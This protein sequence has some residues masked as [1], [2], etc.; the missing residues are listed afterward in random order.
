MTVLN[1]LN[2]N[3]HH[4]GGGG[5]GAGGGNHTQAV[6]HCTY[7]GCPKTYSRRE[8]LNRHI[9][10]HMGIE[11]E[12][13]YYCLDCGKTFTRKEHLLR[14]RRSHTGETPYHCPG[15]DC[16]KQFAR[17]EH[18]KRHMRVHTGEHPYPCSEC[19]RSFGR[20]ERLLKHLETHGIHEL[21]H[22]PRTKKPKEEQDPTDLAYANL[23]KTYPKKEPIKQE[24]D[25]N[26]PETHHGVFG[27]TSELLKMITQT[28]APLS[29]QQ[30]QAYA[31][32]QVAAQGALAA[33]VSPPK[34]V[35]TSGAEGQPPATSH[36]SVS[37][38]ST[39]TVSR[40]PDIANSPAMP[41]ELSKLPSTFSIFPVMQGGSVVQGAVVPVEQ[42]Q[43]S[44]GY[45]QAPG[46]YVATT[47]AAHRPGELTTLPMS[48]PTTLPTGWQM[49][50]PMQPGMVMSRSPAKVEDPAAAY[51]RTN[52][53]S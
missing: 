38:P 49:A 40:G 11:P 48:W 33:F 6:L 25:F 39:T 41:P 15:V 50:M 52:F 30:A 42:V 17:K 46:G 8:H 20:R 43:T 28:K 21:A 29:P 23:R 22:E 24:P 19:G 3:T 9:K 4:G 37:L 31:Q 47:M 26:M 7:E 45:Y 32:A 51:F 34:A 16:A 2:T 5:G 27:Q 36:Q 44:N 10:L 13:P 35:K 14:H 53:S 1:P 18:L 12:R